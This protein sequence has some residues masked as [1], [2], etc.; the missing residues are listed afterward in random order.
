M[1]VHSFSIPLQGIQFINNHDEIAMSAI[2]FANT[3]NMQQNVLL[4]CP[5]HLSFMSHMQH[6]IPQTHAIGPILADV[7]SLGQKRGRGSQQDVIGAVDKDK[8][9][10]HQGRWSQ[11]EHNR[12]VDGLN[13]FG[14]DWEKVQA[15]VQTRSLSQ[16]RSH[17]QKYFLKL[18][19]YE[20]MERLW[21]NR[22][23]LIGTTTTASPFE[24]TSENEGMLLVQLMSCF[25]EQL[26]RKRDQLLDAHQEMEEEEESLDDA[27][28]DLEKGGETTPTSEEKPLKRMKSSSMS[29]D[30]ET[31]PEC[32]SSICT[33]ASANLSDDE[34][35]Q[36]DSLS[37]SPR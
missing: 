14:K 10:E 5:S 30:C 17:A 27:V 11:S 16:I 13:R 37:S 26:K 3:V 8:D 19:K 23:I 32:G 29:D 25:L 1:I 24:E 35:S 6:C 20:E 2:A 9:K 21:D 7:G 31:D 36:H 18:T 33:P 4:S 28:E 12:F 34:L 15:V 22:D